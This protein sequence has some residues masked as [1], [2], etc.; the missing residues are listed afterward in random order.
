MV[1]PNVND[2]MRDEECLLTFSAV[3]TDHFLGANRQTKYGLDKPTLL[4]R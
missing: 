1:L 2:I 4:K 3:R